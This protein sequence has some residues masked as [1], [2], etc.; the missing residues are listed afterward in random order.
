VR[1]RNF[2]L[3]S[4]D[5]FC[6]VSI[7]VLIVER[8]IA[9]L[10]LF[11]SKLRRSQSHHCASQFAVKRITAKAADHYRNA[12][13]AHVRFPYEK[14]QKMNMRVSRSAT[15]PGSLSDLKE[16]GCKS[17]WLVHISPLFRPI[18]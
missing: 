7:V 8:Q 3:Q 4:L 2:A 10:G 18:E 16:I 14:L 17:V 5:W 1:I 6:L 15:I 13:L 12:I 11:E 9:D